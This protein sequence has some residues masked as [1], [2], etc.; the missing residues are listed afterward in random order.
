MTA[1]QVGSLVR[2]YDDLAYEL[3]RVGSAR[4]ID[5]LEPRFGTVTPL[6]Q[7]VYFSLTKQL[8]DGQCAALSRVMATA[9]EHG[10]ELELMRNMYRAA[11]FPKDPASIRFMEKL[12]TLQKQ[13]GGQ[14]S[15]HAGKTY[16]QVTYQNMVKELGD[17]TVSKS[18][19]IDSPGH[20]M[21]AGVKVNGG[22]KVFYFYDPNFGFATFSSANAM[23]AG[24]TK[25]FN[26]KKLVPSYKT[27]GTDPNSLEFRVFDHDDAW[28]QRNSVFR[29]DIEALYNTPIATGPLPPL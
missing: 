17:A 16:R 9:V 26:D 24:L 6:P 20:A 23:E 15:F 2:R 21:A 14:T 22:E 28:Q 27:H 4:F 8:S 10:K 5:N 29:A 12:K 13:V 11:A 1:E 25:V 19:M 7:V 3:G 18:I